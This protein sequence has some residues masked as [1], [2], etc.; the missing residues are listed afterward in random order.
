MDIT[1]TITMTEQQIP[2]LIG[3]LGKMWANP[4]PAKQITIVKVQTE[5]PAPAEKP[6][7]INAEATA[8]APVIPAP[9][10]VKAAP[11]K[12]VTAAQVQQAAGAFM[13]ANPAN[14]TVLQGILADLG[15]QAFPQ[16]KT[17]DQLDTFAQKL[18]EHGVT[19]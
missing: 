14:M 1:F 9:D 17:Q 2:E 15:V 5:A 13:D 4:D 10:P 16:I 11:V 3:L 8:P 7:E 19:V 18:R 6:A 12:P